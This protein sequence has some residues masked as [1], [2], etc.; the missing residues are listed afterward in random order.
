MALVP[1]PEVAAFSK[2]PSNQIGY[3]QAVGG[4][5]ALILAETGHSPLQK[6]SW[7]HRRSIGSGGMPGRPRRIRKNGLS[8]AP[9]LRPFLLANR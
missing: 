6:T 4:E 3:H 5:K 8:A 7:N 1:H 9:A 2:I